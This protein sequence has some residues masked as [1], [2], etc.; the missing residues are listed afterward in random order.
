MADPTVTVAL[1]STGGAVL[2]AAVGGAFTFLASRKP[3][4]E[5]TVQETTAGVTSD[6]V[7]LAALLVKL[8][9]EKEDLEDQRATCLR[10]HRDC[11]EVEQQLVECQKRLAAC[12]R[13]KKA[14]T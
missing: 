12:E 1:V 14:R 7:A 2:V 10:D 3:A 6:A 5:S 13:R 4:T 11:T 8:Y 9:E